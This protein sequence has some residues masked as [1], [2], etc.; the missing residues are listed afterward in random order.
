[1]FAALATVA[2]KVKIKY[3][4]GTFESKKIFYNL[5]KHFKWSFFL[6]KWFQFLLMFFFIVRKL[7]FLTPEAVF[8]VMCDPSMNELW[9]KKTGLCID[10][11]ESRSLT[12][13]SQLKIWSLFPDLRDGLEPKTLGWRGHYAVAFVK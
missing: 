3:D 8:L 2:E 9:A 1:M 10:L 11:Y 12:A 4:F 6:I 5:L 13:R 7:H